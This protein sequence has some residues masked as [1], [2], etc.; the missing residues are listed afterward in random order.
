MNT[1]FRFLCQATLAAFV[2]CTVPRT[3]PAAEKKVDPTGTWTWEI[4]VQDGNTIKRSVKLKLQGDKLTGT[5]TNFEGAEQPIEAAKL[6]GDEI[7]FQ[8]TV[9]FGGNKFVPKYS[10]KVDG[11]KIVGEVKIDRDGETTSRKW[12]AKRVASKANAT[13]T[14][15][16][17]FTTRNGQ[18]LEPTLKLKQDGDKLTGAVIFNENEAP[19]SD[20]KIS[21]GQI[22]FKVQRERDGQ[23][24]TS[25]YT[26]KLTGDNIKGQITSNFG[27]TERTYDFEAKRQKE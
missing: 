25:R 3:T 17:S 6:K 16:Y 11:D 2:L 15:K 22:S 8:Y 26:G 21:D 1:H 9:D 27:G 24:I 13:G 10:G 19:I 12:E 7:S 4:P 18:T 14:W 5:T 23:T 20:G